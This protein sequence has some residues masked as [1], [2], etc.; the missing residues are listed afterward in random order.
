MASQSLHASDGAQEATEV[1]GLS[2]YDEIE[3]HASRR[4]D[5]K[6]TKIKRTGT[7]EDPNEDGDERARWKQD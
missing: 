7:R 4:L 1:G 6:K 5:P 3:G 2:Q